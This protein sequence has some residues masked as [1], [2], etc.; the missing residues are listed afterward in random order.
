M[1][2]KV[3]KLFNFTSFIFSLMNLVWSSR[4]LISK[5]PLGQRL[6]DWWKNLYWHHHHLF[7]HQM[8][9]DHLD[10]WFPNIWANDWWQEGWRDK[11]I[12]HRTP[13]HQNMFWIEGGA[14]LYWHQFK[15]LSTAEQG[16]KISNKS[17]FCVM[18]A[19]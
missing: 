1:N 3:I 12:F 15:I 17:N 19:H 13:T 8:S 2:A 7:A 11:L 14:D 5:H 10:C 9:S 18:M 6:A 4:I 16:Y